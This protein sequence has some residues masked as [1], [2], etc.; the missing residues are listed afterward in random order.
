MR[1]GTE[2]TIFYAL[3][4]L[5]FFLL[6]C[7]NYKKNL[8]SI[9]IS[10]FYVVYSILSIYLYNNA[11]F[12]QNYQEVSIFPYLYLF[13]MILLSLSPVIAYDHAKV[14]GLIRP[15]SSLIDT[16]TYIFIFLALIS[17]PSTISELRT[18]I[19]LLLVDPSGGADLYKDAHGG[20]VGS[21]GLIEIP[22]YLISIFS[23]IS[24]FVF[25]Y[26]LTLRKQRKFMLI[27]LAVT[28]VYNL[29]RPLSLGLRTDAVMTIFAFMG[30][31]VIMYKWI[32]KKRKK[33]LLTLASSIGGLVFCLMMILTVS[34]FED[35][36]GGVGGTNLDYIAQASLNL[37]KY[38]IEAW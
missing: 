7:K 2:I 33:I 37:N 29:L 15:S 11:D 31:Y 9:F 10:F 24:I 19:V 35:R 5:I 26:Y 12:G 27:G 36:A 28:M 21:K 14:R 6:L 3:G 8:T 22:K 38:G 13:A 23:Y 25:F 4:W 34:R 17:L 1:E 20:G 32:P 30:G 18:G 16:F